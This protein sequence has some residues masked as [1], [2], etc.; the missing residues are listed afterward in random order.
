MGGAIGR[1]CEK[2]G[3]KKQSCVAGDDGGEGERKREKWVFLGAE[4][5][6]GRVDIGGRYWWW[7]M[8]RS[9]HDDHKALCWV[10]V[11]RD[12]LCFFIVGSLG[13]H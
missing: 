11:K 5:G 12:V 9:N 3:K 7:S 8:T 1:A 10:L 2:K 4:W 13:W 6:W